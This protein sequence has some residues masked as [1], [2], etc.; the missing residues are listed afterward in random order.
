M[1]YPGTPA[2]KHILQANDVCTRPLAV[3]FNSAEISH[4]NQFTVCYAK[5]SVHGTRSCS[6]TPERM[7]PTGWF[8]SNIYKQINGTG[9]SH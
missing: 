3:L 8:A 5:Q 6:M 9:I 7:S 2:H 4:Q 1:I